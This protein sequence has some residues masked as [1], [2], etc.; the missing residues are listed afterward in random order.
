MNPFHVTEMD[1]SD[2]MSLEV[3]KKAIVNRKNNTARQPVEWLK[4]RWIRVTKDKPL[5][6]SY[7]YS[8]NTLEVWKVVDLKRRSKGRPVDIGLIPL[9]PL[10]PGES[11]PISKP[12]L[13]DLRQ[14]L[15]FVPPIHHS[16]YTELTDNGDHSDGDDP[17]DESESQSESESED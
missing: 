2:F 17:G 11:R 3:I 13:N 4:M 7:R 8:H 9:P 1:T 10:Y 5:Q 12:K 16:F 6:F 14:L 15:P